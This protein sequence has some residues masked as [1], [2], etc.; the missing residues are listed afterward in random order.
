MT[1]EQAEQTIP[2]EVDEIFDIVSSLHEYEQAT[3]DMNHDT[4]GSN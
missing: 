2:E 1:A 3:K 4:D